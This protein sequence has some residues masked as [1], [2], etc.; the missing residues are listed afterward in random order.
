[1]LLVVGVAAGELNPNALPVLAV[2]KDGLA[3]GELLMLDFGSL[4]FVGATK[5]EVDEAI[6]DPKP[7]MGAGSGGE[8][9][10][11]EAEVVVVED[12]DAVVVPE[13]RTW[14]ELLLKGLFVLV[15]EA[16]NGDEEAKV[17]GLEAAVP[18][19]ILEFLAEPP[20]EN[21]PLADVIVGLAEDK[22]S[23]LPNINTDF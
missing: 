14:D 2:A 21:I 5:A 20:N 23:D 19:A 17:D 22:D 6:A 16:G 9:A 18:L 13:D 1:M 12:K 4:S 8:K 7:N 3:K 11:V 10:I 15:P